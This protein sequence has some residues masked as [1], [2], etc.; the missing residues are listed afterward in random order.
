MKI[1]NAI[2]GTAGIGA[3]QATDVIPNTDDYTEI[4]KLL[5]QLAIGVIT[6]I[7]LLKKKKK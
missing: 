4:I 7:G 5:V 1:I 6:I 3:I 2:I